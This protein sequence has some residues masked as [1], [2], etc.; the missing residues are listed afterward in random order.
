MR[1]TSP[2]RVAGART[3]R[4]RPGRGR[5]CASGS[6]S[7]RHSVGGLLVP[8][9]APCRCLRP[10]SAKVA[11][12]RLAG[13]YRGDHTP[14][15]RP[16]TSH[17]I[18]SEKAPC[19]RART[20]APRQGIERWPALTPSNPHARSLRRAARLQEI[21]SKARGFEH[22]DRSLALRAAREAPPSLG[23]RCGARS[24]P[25][26][27]DSAHVFPSAAGA[28]TGR[29]VSGTSR[30]RCVNVLL[31]RRRP[32][33]GPRRTGCSIAARSGSAFGREHVPTAWWPVY[34]GW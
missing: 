32:V 5:E 3:T 29:R 1:T 25:P 23:Q 18:V 11:Q 16:M 9:R 34:F 6:V 30:R 4:R 22:L 15:A 27:S 33:L 14:G 24:A 12:G 17:Q 19:P 13:A 10:V 20:N 7:F 2:A 26:A 28:A 21:G 8:A 31:A